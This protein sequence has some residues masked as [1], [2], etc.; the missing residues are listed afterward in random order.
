MSPARQP[1]LRV[2]HVDY[3][4]GFGGSM[5][6]LSELVAGLRDLGS[7]ESTVL[8]FQSPE[9]FEDFFPHSEL[10]HRPLALT[11][12]TRQALM[13]FLDRQ[14][15]AGP[16]R[17]HAL[18]LYNAVDFVHDYYVAGV[19]SRIVRE[20]HIDIVH[21]NNGWYLTAI[22]G[23]LWGGARCVLHF[24]GFYW[25]PDARSIRERYGA[26]ID[27]AVVGCIGVSDAV[28]D[29]IKAFG[30]PERKVR[31]IYNSVCAERFSDAA[32]RRDEVRAK[33]SISPDQVV[34]AVFGRITPWKG[35][36]E[37]LQSMC[38]VV[39]QYPNLVIMI[40]GDESDSEDRGYMAR[41][42]SFADSGPLAG[43]VVLTGFQK[44]VEDY[45]AAADV[46]VQCSLEPEPFGRVVIEGMA[47]GK[48]VIAVREA[49][50]A[51]VITDGVDGLLVA[52]RDPEAMRAAVA[53]LYVDA[54]LRRRL[55][56]S[57]VPKVRRDYSPRRIASQVSECLEAAAPR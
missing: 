30:V 23:A 34:F 51:E 38:G 31:T 45:F 8:T 3:S 11:Y 28:S 22:R 16:V 6:S 46:V 52:P 24:R 10:I 43:R 21:V 13:A 37:F 14:R 47:A 49:G 5:I 33:Y 27:D 17:A 19:I 15:W 9:P 4:M 7:I 12:R 50:P 40:A 42:R 41:V 32:A 26:A 20:R 2:L 48:A 1:S 29:E 57:G 35:Q 55:G 53:R 25:P 36:L 18:T 56:S 39:E 44:G 54:E